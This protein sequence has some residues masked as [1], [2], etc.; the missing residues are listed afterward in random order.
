MLPRR[1]S[2]VRTAS[3]LEGDTLSELLSIAA[4]TVAKDR[5]RKALPEIDERDI[6][7]MVC[8]RFL[9]RV[10]NVEIKNWSHVQALLR[11]MVSSVITDLLRMKQHMR[12]RVQLGG[13]TEVL[14]QEQFSKRALRFLG[15]SSG[16]ADALSHAI[17]R[18]TTHQIAAALRQ[19]A[20]RGRRAFLRVVMKN[21]TFAAISA[22]YG[23]S[24]R[25]MR[26]HFE[27]A[28][29]HLIVLLSEP[30]VI[31]KPDLNG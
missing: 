19:L 18:E 14:A 29:Q 25:T 28:R 24:E 10:A 22:R 15:A 6:V 5:R 9:G 17:S 12:D 3:P 27:S 4:L 21:E 11:L 20:E 31:P 2:L 8:V 16:G 13:L 23:V 26:R 7:Q 1:S 30:R